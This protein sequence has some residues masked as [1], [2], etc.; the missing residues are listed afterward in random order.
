MAQ[1]G[2]QI[3]GIDYNQSLIE[4]ARASANEA[5]LPNV[6]FLCA[7]LNTDSLDDISSPDLVTC[8][9]T[10][11]HLKNPSDFLSKLSALQNKNGTLLLSV[12]KAKYEPTDS[13]GVPTNTF[14]LHRFSRDD[15]TNLLKNSGYRIEK[16]LGQPY[17]NINMSLHNKA[18]R[19]IGTTKRDAL[20]F[21][22]QSEEAISF[23]ARMFALPTADLYEFSYSTFI[24]A[25]KA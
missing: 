20:N 4:S 6:H 15:L 23:F 21:F 2:A 10:L 8:F 11:E 13:S 17:T 25:K 19:D 3:L 22:D 1:T 18:R 5:Q 24:I 9:D 14:H 16:T 7:N 12:P